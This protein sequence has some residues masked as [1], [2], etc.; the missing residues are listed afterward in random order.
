MDSEVAIPRWHICSSSNKQLGLIKWTVGFNVNSDGKLM[1]RNS[2][3]QPFLEYMTQLWSNCNRTS[4]SKIEGIQRKA[5]KIILN[6]FNNVLPLMLRRSLLHLSFLFN[7]MMD[8]SCIPLKIV[9]A[10]QLARRTC[11]HLSVSTIQ[12]DC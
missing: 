2:L 4:V 11:D 7:I 6:D 5:T 9:F 12:Q 1:C 3:V 10:F 8:N